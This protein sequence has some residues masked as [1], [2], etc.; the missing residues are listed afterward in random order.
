MFPDA[1]IRKAEDEIAQ[2]KSTRRTSQPGSGHEK[3]RPG[4]NHTLLDG[5]DKSLPNPLATL[6]R[7][8]QPE[9]VLAPVVEAE[10]GAVEA[11]LTA[12][13]DVPRITIYPQCC[14]CPTGG[15]M[16][17]KLLAV[18]GPP[19][20]KSE[21]DIYPERGLCAPIQTQAPSSETPPDNQWLCQ[22][23]QKQVSEG[24]RSKPSGQKGS[25]DGEG[26]SISSL[27]QQTVHGPQ[28]KP[29]VAASLRS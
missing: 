22:S 6:E 17:P 11:P 25:R 16:P 2:F 5:R 24:G 21:S 8:C 14:S 1:I 15:R 12:V 4:I 10:V 26:S 29:K 28:T 27:F 9:R 18:L 23:Q 20:G 7:I 19:R 13:P 3:V